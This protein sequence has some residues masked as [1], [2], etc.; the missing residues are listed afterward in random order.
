MANVG[1]NAMRGSEEEWKY[2]DNRVQRT[3]TT[4]TYGANG[5]KTE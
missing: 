2:M 1:S 4:K 5:V 3:M